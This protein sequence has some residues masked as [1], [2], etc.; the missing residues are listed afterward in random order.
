MRARLTNAMNEII[1]ADNAS[2]EAKEVLKAWV[3]NQNDADKTK[4]WLLR[5]WLLLKKVSLHG[6]PLSAQIKGAFSLPGKTFTV[7]YRW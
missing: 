7:D 6:C 1:A 2:A 3:E 5:Y 4:N